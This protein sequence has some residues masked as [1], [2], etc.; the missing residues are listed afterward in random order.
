MKK[1]IN[2]AIKAHLIRGAFLLVFFAGVLLALF[3]ASSPGGP[4]EAKP[5]TLTRPINGVIGG[6]GT[7]GANCYTITSGTDTI[8]PGTTDTGNHCVWCETPI[9]LPFPFVLYDQTFNAVN[10]SSSGRL[11]FVCANDPANLLETC[12]P[13]P[14]N[15]CPFDY[16]IFPLWYEWSTLTDAP[17]CSAWANGCGIFTSISGTA[18]NRIFNIEWHVVNRY[19]DVETADFE[20]RLYE[21]DPNKRFDVIYGSITQGLNTGY[22]VAGV[23]GPTGFFIQNFCRTSPPQNVSRTYAVMIP[24][25]TPTA[26]ATA[27]P[28]PTPAGNIIVTNTNDSGPGSLRQALADANDGDTI[29]FAVSGTIGLTSGELVIDKNITISGPGSNVLTV[30]RSSGSF[31]VFHVMP[32]HTVTIQGITISFGYGGSGGGGIYLDDHVTASIADCSLT[33]NIGGAVFIDG[34]GGTM[35]TV[36]NSSITDNS[37]GSSELGGNGG[38]IYNN[39]GTLTIIGSTISHNT[40]WFGDFLGGG[41]GGILNAY[42]TLV[43]SNTTIR[44]NQAGLSGGGISGNGTITI[45][46][47]T[48]S[49][50][51][52]G[53]TGGQGATGFG[54][55]IWSSG[56]LTVT[57]CT[58]SGNVANGSTFKGGGVGGGIYNGGSADVGNS[59]SSDNY[60]GVHGGSIYGGTFDIGNSVLNGGS[61]EN[62]Y[63][64]AVTSHG[65]NVCSDNGGGFFNGPGDQ[66][67]TDPMLGPLQNNGGLTFTHEL[68]TGSPAIDAGDPNFTPPPYYDQRGPVFWRMR[69]GRIDVGSFE[70]QV[71]TTP[72]PTPT[73]SPT[74]TPTATPPSGGCIDAWTPTS[75]TNAPDGRDDHTAV[76]TGSEMI[77]WGG[78]VNGNASNTGGRYNPVTN[79]WTATSTTNAPA[80]RYLHT[81]VWTGSEMIIWG[82]WNGNILNTGGRY[83]P[84]TNTWTATSVAGAPPA[85]WHHT[86]VW[87]GSEM[88]VWGGEDRNG[89]AL[90]TGGRYNP[91]TDT[92]TATSTTSAPSARNDHTAVWTSSEMIVWGGFGLSGQTNTGGRY[93]PGTDSWTATSTTNA[94]EGRERHTAV[95]TGSEMIIWGGLR[96]FIQLNTGGRYNPNTDSWTATTLTNVPAART[97]H[98]AV[99][100]GSQMIVWGGDIGVDVNT[101]GRYDPGTDSWTATSTTSAPDGRAVHTAVWTGSEMI[102]WGGVGHGS[103]LNTGGRYCA[104][105][106]SPTPTPTPT[107][108]PTLTARPSP[109][110][111]QALTPRPRPTPPPRP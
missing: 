45:T 8:V 43:I 111:R 36:L 19:N 97:A 6:N 63:G 9:T 60:A 54:G 13:A 23:Q 94:P 3:A 110:P 80:A 75:L 108:T 4:R 109:T 28:T 47:S 106:L 35:L 38:G 37:A 105:A 79:T 52:A 16:T 53:E 46:D 49:G 86:A 89:N 59:T 33:N 85:R 7:D 11:D 71:G 83:N 1:Q 29:G 39:A 72:S 27:T 34:Y 103:Y 50:N 93:N 25:P 58:I 30:R 67:N 31:R 78:Y 41:G 56:T 92:W 73:A 22:D 5:P 70:V 88:I 14:P 24:C 21:N 26:T 2:P 104:A 51:V 68:L 102:V 62:I 66:I 98:T 17:A 18:P 99:W 77:I 44:N 95:W 100:T 64:A 90:N 10:V 42:G 48:I 91:N 57:N 76:W 87:T 84:S 20:V 82:G 55:G 81:A 12:L 15:N 61:P 101:G 69:N 107:A 32:G 96:P 65:Y 74:P 40:A